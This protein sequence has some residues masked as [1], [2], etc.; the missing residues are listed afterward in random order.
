MNENDYIE[1][2]VT[3]TNNID[4]LK[5]EREKL[6]NNVLDTPLFDSKNF[7]QDLENKLLQIYKR[8]L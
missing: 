8:K 6:F 3:L 7:A 2:A 4:K 5:F 1:K